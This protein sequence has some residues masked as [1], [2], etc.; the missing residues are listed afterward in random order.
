ME[1]GLLLLSTLMVKMEMKKELLNKCLW[2]ISYHCSSKENSFV[3]KTGL[4]DK[5][6]EMAVDGKLSEECLYPLGRIIAIMSTGT[7]N[8]IKRMMEYEVLEFLSLLL[9]SKS[10][11][12]QE[13]GCLILSNFIASNEDIASSIY[14]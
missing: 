8:C 1:K 5:V 10:S 4:F 6:M 2:A 9:E 7:V 3:M 13:K 11:T 14:K 12:L